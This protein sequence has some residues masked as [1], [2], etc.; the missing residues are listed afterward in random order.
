M[1]DLIVLLG[2]YSEDKFV[3]RLGRHYSGDV[4]S[5]F[6]VFTLLAIG[7]EWCINEDITVLA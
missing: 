4:S 7:A 1:F 3:G 5:Y 6:V 2:L